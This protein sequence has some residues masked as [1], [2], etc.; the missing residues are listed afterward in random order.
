MSVIKERTIKKEM[1]TTKIAITIEKRKGSIIPV[2]LRSRQ[3]R[4]YTY[5]THYF[6][7]NL[8]SYKSNIAGRTCDSIYI[9]T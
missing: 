4:F 5:K 1:V 9:D 7:A 8:K 3:Q 2:L 6:V